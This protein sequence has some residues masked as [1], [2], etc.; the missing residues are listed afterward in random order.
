MQDSQNQHRFILDT[1]EDAMAPV[2][3]APHRRPEPGINRR[4]L[5]EFTKPFACDLQACKI[6]VSNVK[7]ETL[8]AENGDLIKIRTGFSAE[9]QPSH[10]A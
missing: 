3:Q 4:Q 6:G 10:R 7:S 5:G 8:N 1:I 2:D 9:T